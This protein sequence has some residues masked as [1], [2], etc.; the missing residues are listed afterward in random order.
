MLEGSGAIV[1]EE[2]MPDPG[3]RV[4]FEERCENQPALPCD[5]RREVRFVCSVR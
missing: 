2:E 1:L 3:E 4:T 5:E